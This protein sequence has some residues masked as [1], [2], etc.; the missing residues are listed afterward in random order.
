MIP[1]R[2]KFPNLTL[3]CRSMNS[4]SRIGSVPGRPPYADE[5]TSKVDR[6]SYAFMLIE[7]G[8][9]KPLPN[10]VKA[11]YPMGKIFDQQVVY[12]WKLEYCP[13]CLLIGHSCQN[14]P[15]KK[16]SNM[17]QEMPTKQKTVWQKREETTTAPKDNG[18]NKT[19]Q[20][21]P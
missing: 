20:T 11:R 6:V 5:C 3:N 4:L 15:Q 8:V 18:Q 13:T 12:D 1:L 21:I 9:T 16:T 2:V 14:P 19:L 10:S 7:M 17:A